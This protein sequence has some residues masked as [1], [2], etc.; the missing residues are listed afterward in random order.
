MIALIQSSTVL[1]LVAAQ[2]RQAE[3]TRVCEH[4]LLAADVSDDRMQGITG[5]AAAASTREGGGGGVGG[6]SEKSEKGQ[7]RAI[8]CGHQMIAEASLTGW[9]G[10]CCGGGGGGGE[11][12]VGEGGV[13]PPP[14]T[15]V[16]VSFCGHGMHTDCLK[17]FME[18]KQQRSMQVYLNIST[19]R[20]QHANMLVRRTYTYVPVY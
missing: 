8:L 4:Q 9:E 3:E 19:L 13:C 20:Y 18:S 14:A 16:V 6:G 10:V 17:R 1:S 15:G 11:S 5:A 12:G 7:Q 2:Q